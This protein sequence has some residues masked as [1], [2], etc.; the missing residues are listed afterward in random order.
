MR[1]TVA[2]AESSRISEDEYRQLDALQLLKHGLGLSKS[3]ARPFSLLYLY[4]EDDGG[5][6]I[7][8]L[9]RAE[10]RRFASAVDE[11]LAF[12]AMTYQ[13]LFA[14]LSELD[15]VEHTYLDYLRGRYFRE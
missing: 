6:A 8:D 5:S 7:G 15:G 12:R 11:D 10:I 9:H 1:S 2:A 3:A 4:Y 14:A 13:G